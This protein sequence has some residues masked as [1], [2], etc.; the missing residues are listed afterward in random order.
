MKLSGLTYSNPACVMKPKLMLSP[1]ARYARPGACSAAERKIVDERIMTK[2]MGARRADFM[3]ILHRAG[4][5]RVGSSDFCNSENGRIIYQ[6][7][8]LASQRK[9]VTAGVNGLI[10]S[11]GNGRH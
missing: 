10:A 9:F 4:V 11:A 8:F 3:G 5:S 7:A 1:T 2:R 6:P